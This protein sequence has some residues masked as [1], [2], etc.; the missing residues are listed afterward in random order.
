V[1]E[2]GT[3]TQAGVAWLWVQRWSKRRIGP[4]SRTSDEPSRATPFSGTSP[5]PERRAS[6]WRITYGHVSGAAAAAE[7]EVDWMEAGGTSGGWELSIG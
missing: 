4:V 1:L 3:T 5:R 6:Q 7:R 2:L